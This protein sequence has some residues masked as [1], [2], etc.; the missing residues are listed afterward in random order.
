MSTTI[1]GVSINPVDFSHNT[2]SSI[3]DVDD[4]DDQSIEDWRVS[5]MDR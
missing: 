1:T 5:W 3:Y 2:K 4:E